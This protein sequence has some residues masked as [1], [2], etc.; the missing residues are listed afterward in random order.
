MKRN[1]ICGVVLAAAAASV[2]LPA[3]ATVD[4]QCI[5]RWQQTISTRALDE[6]CKTLD[7]ATA[8]KLKALEDSSLACATA[9]ATADEKAQLDTALPQIRQ[10][11]TKVMAETP[12]DESARAAV[13]GQATRQLAK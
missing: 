13:S 7:A 9:K 6:R 2:A 8:A 12:C 11:T 1:S 5:Q 4:E 10:S 3:A